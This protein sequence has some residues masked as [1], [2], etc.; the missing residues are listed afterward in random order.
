MFAMICWLIGATQAGEWQFSLGGEINDAPHGTLDLSWRR[1]A[2]RAELLTDTL[3]I[4]W[5]PESERGRW[6]V[7]ARA[8]GRGAGLM[9]APWTDGAPDPT[10]ALTASY[11]GSQGGWLRYLPHGLY[12]GAAG[13]ARLYTFGALS[14]TTIEVPGTTPWLNAD[15][16]V[17]WWTS[18]VNGWIRAGADWLGEGLSPHVAGELNAQPDWTLAPRAELRAGWAEGQ[19]IV[20]RTR[21]GGLNPYVVPLAG[22]YWAEWW[23]E[24][25]V[26]LRTGP[27]W[28]A[29]T[30][31][32]EVTVDAVWFDGQT[33]LGFGAEAR[34]QPSLWFG[35][36]A[37]GY[38]PWI[39]RQDGLAPASVWF[40]VG[41]SWG[42]I[43]RD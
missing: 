10:R 16:I 25:Y 4:S 35:E 38:A 23:V 33:A 1:E 34:Y 2:L 28:S 32:A 21:L 12:A 9:P 15:A 29:D 37:G 43:G 26:A 40:L 19:T 30:W 41:R 39:P 14:E 22:A 17:G 24:D 7:A 42:A 31:R 20:N 18:S 11:V 3:Q 36:L 6:W 5:N 27:I 8:E 13:H